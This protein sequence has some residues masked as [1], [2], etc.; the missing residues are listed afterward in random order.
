MRR[1]QRKPF[2]Y[3]F[4]MGAVRGVDSVILQRKKTGAFTA[5][6]RVEHLRWNKR[7]DELGEQTVLIHPDHDGRR[8]IRG[9]FKSVRLMVYG[10]L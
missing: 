1:R 3:A 2:E 5:A 7:P 10:E 9:F 6:Y 4:V 8:V